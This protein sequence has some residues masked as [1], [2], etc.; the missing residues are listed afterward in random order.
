[1]PPR[2]GFCNYCEKE[3]FSTFRNI[4]EEA[5]KKAEKGEFIVNVGDSLCSNCYNSVVQYDRN[6][7]YKNNIFYVNVN[8]KQNV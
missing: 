7:R 5:K 3:K 4:T 2:N 1:M 8:K 6:Q